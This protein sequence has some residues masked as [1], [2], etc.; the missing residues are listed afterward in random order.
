M[1]IPPPRIVVDDRQ[2]ADINSGLK[3]VIRQTDDG[4]R[5]IGGGTVEFLVVEGRVRALLQR[6]SLGG[7]R[8]LEPGCLDGHL[9]VGLC[10]AGADVTAC[11][12]RPMCLIKTF[13]RCLAFGF[14]PRLLLHDARRLSELGTF[15]VIFHSGLLYHLDNP[16]DHFREI[17]SIAP[18][19]LLDT[20]T[21]KPGEPLDTLAGYQGM[22]YR[23]FGWQDEQSGLEAK[24]LWPTRPELRRLFIECGFRYEAIRETDDGPDGP[25]GLYLL[26]K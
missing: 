19:I 3:W 14:Q 11:D 26:R 17:A 18:V 7:L 16:I 2:L 4:G 5:A 21:A 24:S 23:E 13:A 25:R 22:W 1:E 20:H 9:T 15:D 12:I 6:M 8:V 10:A